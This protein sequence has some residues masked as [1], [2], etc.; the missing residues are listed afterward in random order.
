MSNASIRYT[1]SFTVFWSPLANWERAGGT[2]AGVMSYLWAA[3]TKLPKGDGDPS[4]G[5]DGFLL[6]PTL[7]RL[8]LPSCQIDWATTTGQLSTPATPKWADSAVN[9]R[10]LR[11]S[12]PSNNCR[13]AVCVWT[14]LFSYSLTLK[15]GNANS[16]SLEYIL[17]IKWFLA[18]SYS[19]SNIAT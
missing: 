7:G 10:L 8:L 9:L 17:G 4:E 15:W 6:S 12:L 3:T 5:M 18:I 1:F 16:K 2:A 19:F 13:K 14:W 11:S